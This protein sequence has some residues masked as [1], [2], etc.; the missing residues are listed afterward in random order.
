MKILLINASPR[1]NGA[2]AKV[3]NEFVSNLKLCGGAETT[4]VHLSET[5][6]E[7]CKGCCAC[8]KTGNCFIDDD[9]DSLSRAISQADGLII[10]T[11]CYASNVTGQLKTFIDRGHFVFEQLLKDKHVL[12][13]VTY[14]NA[15]G[16]AAFK[17]L[18]KLFLF[19]GARTI[20]KLIIKLPFNSDPL[21]SGN[22][23][24]SKAI[25]FYKK[26]H[27]NK[28]KNI[29]NT[30]IHSAVFNFGIKPF[31]KRKG[32]LYSGV[33]THWRNRGIL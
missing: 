26:I 33:L 5:R 24:K 19:S 16:G 30:I 27:S 17:V 2:T 32:E 28:P 18:K 10:G 7:F 8:Y 23:I 6:L 21:V 20:D 14:E 15:E 9:A 31:V 3:L 22:K 25:S 12:G 4:L 11:P 13:V 29:P 1:K